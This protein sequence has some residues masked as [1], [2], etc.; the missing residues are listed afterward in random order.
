MF[1]VVGIGQR[2]LWT[3]YRYSGSLRISPTPFLN[4]GGLETWMLGSLDSWKFTS[5]T[6]TGRGRPQG[7]I[8]ETEIRLFPKNHDFSKKRPPAGQHSRNGNPFIS[9]KSRNPYWSLFDPHWSLLIPSD[10]KCACMIRLSWPV[11]AGQHR[12]AW[13]ATALQLS[14]LYVIRVRTHTPAQFG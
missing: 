13:V 5:F 9:K 11:P 12:G 1:F 8:V 10:L 4:A 6:A 3:V 14:Y 7:N 2:L